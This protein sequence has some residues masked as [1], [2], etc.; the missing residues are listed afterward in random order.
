MAGKN[1]KGSTWQEAY[2]AIEEQILSSQLK[3][4]EKIT[5]IGMTEKLGFGRT[6]V[7]EAMNKLEQEGLIIVENNRKR[8]YLLTIKEADQI[9]D[10]KILLESAICAWAA[11][12][13]TAG[14][15]KELKMILEDM[16]KLVTV[17]PSEEE[18]EKVWFKK[19]LEKDVALHSLIFKMAGNPKAEKFIEN[20]NKQWHQLRIGLMAMEDRIDKSIEEHELIVEAIIKGDSEAAKDAMIHHLGNLR[21]VL[22]QILKVFNYPFA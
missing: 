13:G 8:V 5:E 20:L 10:I 16:Q 3:P 12:R 7:R 11:E 14:E 4:G 22:I 2:K 21:K 18:R 9:F 17:R 15:Y 6:P 19:W 1:N